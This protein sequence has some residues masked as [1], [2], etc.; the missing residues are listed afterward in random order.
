M[1]N[2]NDTSKTS[3]TFP[4]EKGGEDQ[5]NA[6]PEFEIEVQDDTPE[7][8]RGRTPLPEPAGDVTDEELQHYQSPR[9][10]QR[11]QQ[12]GKGIHDERRS[13]EAAQ[14]ERD[15]AVRIAQQ[16]VEENKRLQGSLATN[17]NVMLTQAKASVAQEIEEAKREYKAAYET[18]DADGVTAAQA[19]L[20][21]ASIK[22]DRVNNFAPAPVQTADKSVQTRPNQQPP[23]VGAKTMEWAER[24][25]WFA[26]DRKMREYAIAAS[27][28]LIDAGV[29]AESDE[30][31][32]RIDSDLR[33][34]FPEAF[35]GESADANT[36]QRQKPNVVASASR[37]TQTKKIVLTQTQVAVAKRL[38]VPLEAYARQV[39]IERSKQNG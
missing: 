34:R 7:V 1:A 25:P 18:G 27:D 23:Q 35:A 26:K 9:A 32:K 28:E 17:H 16:V 37:S 21:A 38:G 36:S 24:N 29:P 8:D 14:R 20:T 12:L 33:G 31:F 6:A 39:A 22:A 11:I 5:N 30:F 13:K 4:D 19:K 15:E 3:F 10:K 2:A